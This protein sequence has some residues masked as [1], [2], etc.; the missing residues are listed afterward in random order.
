MFEKKCAVM[1][2]FSFFDTY[3][4][5]VPFESLNNKIS[6]WANS[7]KY[8]VAVILEHW[9]SSWYS[10]FNISLFYKNH[11]LYL[12]EIKTISTGGIKNRDKKVV[13]KRPNSWSCMCSQTCITIWKLSEYDILNGSLRFLSDSCPIPPRSMPT[14]QV[15]MDAQW[16]PWKPCGVS[17]GMPGEW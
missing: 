6:F 12:S 2:Q 9:L 5:P 4:L 1:M 7:V 13:H 17:W 8:R 10:L 11:R 3:K 14:Y 16:S 15:G